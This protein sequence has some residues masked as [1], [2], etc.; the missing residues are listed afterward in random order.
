[1]IVIGIAQQQQQGP[2]LALTPN[3]IRPTPRT[4]PPH[5][6]TQP[7]TNP[8][9]AFEIAQHYHAIFDTPAVQADPAQWQP[10]LQACIIF[11]VVSPHRFVGRSMDG[12]VRST[13]TPLS[14]QGLARPLANRLNPTR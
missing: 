11:L 12:S 5:T 3:P 7:S 14:D 4:S 2:T 1:M 9:D 8:Q 10:A 6:H 13:A